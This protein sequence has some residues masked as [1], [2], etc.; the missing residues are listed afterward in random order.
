MF[1]FVPA[2]YNQNRTWDDNTSPWFHVFA[3]MNF[4]DTVNQVKMF[5][6][7]NEQ[8]TLLVLNYQ[9][10]LRYFL[11]NQDLLGVDYYSFFDDI[12]N[13][14]AQSVT[15]VHFR[16]LNWPKGTYFVFTPFMVVAKQNDQELAHITQAENGNL[17]NI[18]FFREGRAYCRYLFDDR[19]FAS[20]IIHF[21]DDGHEQSQRY[22][23]ECG[24]WQFEVD[25]KGG[26]PAIYINPASDKLFAQATYEN[27]ETLLAERLSLLEKRM[28]SDD[29][30][31]IAAEQRHNQLLDTV[32]SRKRLVYSFF[33]NRYHLSDVEQFGKDVANAALLVSDSKST[34]DAVQQT[35]MAIDLEKAHVSL[36][37][38][39]TRL[40]LGRS[41]TMKQLNT[42]FFI[43]TISHDTLMRHIAV[44]LAVMEENPYIHLRLISYRPELDMDELK[45]EIYHLIERQFSVEAFIEIENLDQG[46]NAIDEQLEEAMPRIETYIMHNETEIIKNLDAARLILDLGQEPDLYT[47]IAGISAGIPQLNAVESDFVEHGKNGKII[48][49]DQEL[50][51]ALHFYYDGLANWNRSLVHSVQKM[52]DYTSGRLLERW[53]ALL[54][55][56]SHG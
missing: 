45:K 24:V 9:P 52:A 14:S 3:R 50:E 47:Q 34:F 36:P 54:E 7:A 8:T 49:T 42:Y 29:V 17:L 23:N 38:F 51:E 35:L 43:D 40:R 55:E 31:I 48:T 21:D 15:P 22:L 4:D 27:F 44:I 18:L 19:G 13:I 12:Q 10:Q 28:A 53:K 1:Y 41:Q 2:W 25:L 46:E 37:I 39:D 26:Q 56:N 6:N 5:R 30:L 32:F 16:E 33:Q 20:S 11:H